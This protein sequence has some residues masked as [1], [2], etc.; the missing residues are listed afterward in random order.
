MP[1][2]AYDGRYP[3]T[4]CRAVADGPLSL[5][6]DGLQELLT[7]ALPSARQLRSTRP[8]GAATT[9]R[10]IGEPTI[11]H[12]CAPTHA[13]ELTVAGALAT[14][15]TVRTHRRRGRRQSDRT[16]EGDIG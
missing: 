9:L 12:R 4:G 11:L 8:G 14:Q 15:R 5:Y 13:G 3:E 16:L 2:R 7:T 10:R 6:A 1:S